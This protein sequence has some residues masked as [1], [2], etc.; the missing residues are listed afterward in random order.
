MEHAG[1]AALLN[2]SQSA[3]QHVKQAEGLPRLLAR[4]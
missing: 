2:G 1:N 3:L 4:T